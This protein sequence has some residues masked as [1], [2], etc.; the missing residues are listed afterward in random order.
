MVNS[1]L[2]LVLLP[3][4]LNALLHHVSATQAEGHILCRP[5]FFLPEFDSA[6]GTDFLVGSEGS[7]SHV[8]R[9]FVHTT[10]IILVTEGCK[11]VVIVPPRLERKY[12]N[13]TPAT[14]GMQDEV[15]LCCVWWQCVCNIA[16]APANS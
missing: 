5:R 6:S 3:S 2:S 12:W 11:R 9:D 14:Q 4:V 1:D 10:S 7:W 16:V 15:S 13:W 8:H